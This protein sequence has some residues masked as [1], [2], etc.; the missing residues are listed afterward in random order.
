[1]YPASPCGRHSGSLLVSE[2]H[3]TG[4]FTAVAFL[5]EPQQ[6]LPRAVGAEQTGGGMVRVLA[7]GLVCSVG[8]R[9]RRSPAGWFVGTGLLGESGRG[10]PK[11]NVKS[12]RVP[13]GARSSPRRTELL[14]GI[15]STAGSAFSCDGRPRQQSG[16]EELRAVE[17]P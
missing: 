13:G 7:V 8:T 11:A 16:H 4:S 6:F 15:L 10:A 5:Q 12:K 17:A 14:T 3:S 1:M 9:R 2:K